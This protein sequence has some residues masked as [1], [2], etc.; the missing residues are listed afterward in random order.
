MKGSQED[1]PDGQ[2]PTTVAEDL[3]RQISESVTVRSVVSRRAGR[4]GLTRPAPERPAA[5][6][7]PPLAPPQPAGAAPALEPVAPVA[8]PAAPPVSLPEAPAFSPPAPLELPVPRAP[9]PAEPATE[10]FPAP[11]PPRPVLAVFCF[12]APDCA[13]GRYV[14]RTLPLLAARQTR[15]HL[16]SRQPFNL[17]AKGLRTHV[18]G[19]GDSA[20]LQ[21]DA[22]QFTQA[23][24][25]AFEAECGAESAGVTALGFEWVSVN[26]LLEL[27]RARQVGILLSLHSLEK[28]RSDMAGELSR[29]IQDIEVAGLAKAQAVLIHNAATGDEAGNLLPQCKDRLVPVAEAFPVDDFC[30]GLDAGAVKARFQVGP[31]DPTVLFVGE[32]DDRHGPDII[33]KAAH[34]VLKNQPQVRF[35]FVGDGAQLWPLRVH[36][37]YLQL[38][39]AVR[40]VGHLEGKALHELLEAADIVCLP[41]R[42]ATED[43]PILAGWAAKHPVLATHNVGGQLIQHEQDGVLFYPSENSCV[44]GIERVLRDEEL[45]ERVR[46]NGHQKLLARYGWGQAAAQLEELMCKR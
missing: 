34:D 27:E 20:D 37:R 42:E 39:H 2:A 45:R 44:W 4:G 18:L 30:S 10:L 32:L 5:L 33:M 1:E 40:V 11:V 3:I 23:S 43:W 28:Q 16:F 14:A 6:P 21:A 41:S 9:G 36:A 35:V 26:L 29:A 8:A 15:V 17:E 24:L 31:I 19:G 46:Q 13:I 38:E 22:Q 25:A 7:E 12:H